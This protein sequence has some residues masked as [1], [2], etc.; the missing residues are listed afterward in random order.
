MVPFVV[1]PFLARIPN[2][3]ICSITIRS[4]VVQLTP[5]VLVIHAHSPVPHADG[6][7]SK[8]GKA[9]RIISHAGDHYGGVCER[10]N[11]RHGRHFSSTTS[12]KAQRGARTLF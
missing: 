6:K 9:L 2:V 3:P 7:V 4:S 11:P 12:L 8:D 10:D 5:F 1:Y